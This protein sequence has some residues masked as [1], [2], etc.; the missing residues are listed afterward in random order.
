VGWSLERREEDK[1]RRL[2]KKI[3]RSKIRSKAVRRLKKYQGAAVEDRAE[4]FFFL[5][6]QIFSIFLFFNGNH[7]YFEIR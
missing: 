7:R 6:F 3:G 5:V 4:R 1:Y 2:V